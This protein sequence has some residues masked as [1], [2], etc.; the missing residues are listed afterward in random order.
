MRLSP[1]TL[2]LASSITA[3]GIFYL[4]LFFPDSPTPHFFYAISLH[5][6][7]LWWS[8][9]GT[10]ILFVLP[11]I[12]AS[13]ISYFSWTAC[14]LPFG[15][16]AAYLE[17]T[18]WAAVIC[19]EIWAGT[20]AGGMAWLSGGETFG[21]IWKVLGPLCYLV[22]LT[23]IFLY[24]LYWEFWHC[25]LDWLLGISPYGIIYQWRS[26]WAYP[27]FPCCILAAGLGSTKFART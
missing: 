24:Y 25:R 19:L 8:I 12:R 21:R 2:W 20:V 16:V 9:R 11:G 3:G 18:P 14:C 13:V 17:D 23:P 6:Y 7:T 15:I 26:L 5:P 27:V 1:I 10:L 4:V 22:A